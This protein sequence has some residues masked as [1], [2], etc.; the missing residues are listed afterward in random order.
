MSKT[1][2]SSTTTRKAVCQHTVLYHYDVIT[3]DVIRIGY[4]VI[5]ISDDVIVI[6]GDVIIIIISGDV[7]I[8][9]DEVIIISD[10]VIIITDDV[11]CYNVMTSHDVIGIG[12]TNGRMMFDSP[13]IRPL[14]TRLVAPSLISASH[15]GPGCDMPTSSNITELKST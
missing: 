6:S 7:V 5:G 9:A 11:I 3:H 12:I 1:P 15:Y 4:D 10:D 2:H 13:K 8:I 14:P